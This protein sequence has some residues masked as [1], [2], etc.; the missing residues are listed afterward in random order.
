MVIG[1]TMESGTG[2]A[3]ADE[4]RRLQQALSRVLRPESIGP[5]L[6]TPND[7]FSGLRPIEAIERG[8]ADRIWRMIHELESGTPT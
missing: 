8:E 2:H 5:W 6:R 1:M 4:L 3:K 7:A